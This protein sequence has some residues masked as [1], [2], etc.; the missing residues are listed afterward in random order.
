MDQESCAR[1]RSSGKILY[2]LFMPKWHSVMVVYTEEIQGFGVLSKMSRYAN[3]GSVAM[4][5]GCDT[6]RP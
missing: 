3:P 5:G 2:E 4:Y 6:Q 1:F